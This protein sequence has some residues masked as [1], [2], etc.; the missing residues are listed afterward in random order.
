MRISGS[1]YLWTFTTPDVVTLSDLAGRWAAMTSGHRWRRMKVRWIRVYEKHPNGHGWHVHCAAVEFYSVMAIRA[2]AT[3]YGFGR[4]NVTRIPLD[5]SEYLL[6]YL[7]KSKRAPDSRGSR[8]WAC[9]GFKGTTLASVRGF[10]TWWDYVWSLSPPGRSPNNTLTMAVTEALYNRV[11]NPARVKKQNISMNEK[12]SANALSL[13]KSGATVRFCEY[14][15]C[16]LREAA[17]W[18]DGKPHPSLKQYYVQ[19]FLEC[20]GKPMLVEERLAGNVKPA[21]IDPPAKTGQTLVFE[22]VSSREYKGVVTLGGH[23]HVIA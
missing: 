17:Q 16:D 20:G 4:L 6:K 13:L 14:R 3:Q 23:F 1:V 19:H 18:E 5:R 9:Q 2:H 22:Q 8:L 11:G 12:Q 15:R 21:K 10:D 7:L